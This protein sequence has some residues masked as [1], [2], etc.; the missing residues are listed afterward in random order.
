MGVV[1]A[2]K[3]VNARAMWVT[4]AWRANCSVP[5]SARTK[6]I[7]LR[8][9]ACALPASWVWIAQS[10]VAVMAMEVVM[11]LELASAKTAG[12]VMTAQ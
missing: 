2:R 3:T 8:V 7:A 5:M 11:T 1:I 4:A 6:A 12:T 9:L 10:Q